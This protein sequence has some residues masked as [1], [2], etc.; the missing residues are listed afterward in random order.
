MLLDMISETLYSSQKK[1][2]ITR[3]AREMMQIAYPPLLLLMDEVRFYAIPVHT[4]FHTIL[5]VIHW[6]F[7]MLPFSRLCQ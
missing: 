6:E 4:N 2:N 1:Q 5:D 7:R 3:L